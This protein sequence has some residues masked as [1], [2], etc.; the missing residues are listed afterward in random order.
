MNVF[1]ENGRVGWTVAFCT[2][3]ITSSLIQPRSKRWLSWLTINPPGQLK[4]KASIPT[5]EGESTGLDDHDT[6]VA[7]EW[8]FLAGVFTSDFS[9]FDANFELTLS[10]SEQRSWPTPGNLWQG[11][12]CFVRVP[13]THWG[14]SVGIEREAE[15]GRIF[16]VR[17]HKQFYWRLFVLH[18]LLTM[19]LINE[20]EIW[21]FTCWGQ[22]SC[23]YWY[24][25]HLT[26]T[27]L[28]F[29]SKAFNPSTCT[30]PPNCFLL[31]PAWSQHT[32]MQVP[33][34]HMLCMM[35]RQTWRKRTEGCHCS[36]IV[37]S[38]F[39]ILTS[40]FPPI[41]T[42][43]PCLDSRHRLKKSSTKPI[44]VHFSC[45]WTQ[46]VDRGQIH[47]HHWSELIELNQ[48][49]ESC[50]DMREERQFPVRNVLPFG[51]SP[52]RKSA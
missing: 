20:T 17:G 35:R 33:C 32:F 18:W 13:H 19:A 4:F 10:W 1:I 49:T 5:D 52:A 27:T 31:P 45:C 11:V 29:L 34:F 39:S 46:A 38:S 2:S 9:V 14:F 24:F 21:R 48:W 40:P 25:H 30:F 41:L 3:L 44:S 22:A 36:F 8:S 37:Y 6:L 51:P 12:L 16:G 23:T 15:A 7:L 42:H 47:K 28:L 50:W 26:T 43:P